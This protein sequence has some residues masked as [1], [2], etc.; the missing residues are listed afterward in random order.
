V[1]RRAGNVDGDP[2]QAAAHDGGERLGGVGGEV[3][4]V[5]DAYR[6]ERSGEH[7]DLRLVGDRQT[8]RDGDTDA[9]LVGM[10]GQPAMPGGCCVGWA[11]SV[12]QASGM[13]WRRSRV[14]NPPASSFTGFRFPPDVITVAV[15]WYLRFGLSYRDVEEL[16]AERGVEVDHVTV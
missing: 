6:A 9:A 13:R 16:L 5:G 15:G 7:G 2:Q 14:R 11:L 8:R 12:G 1:E 3:V 4:V 10:R